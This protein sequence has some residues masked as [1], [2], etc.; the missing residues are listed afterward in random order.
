MRYTANF[1]IFFVGLL[2]CSISFYQ[3]SSGEADSVLP[4][5]VDFNYNIK[6]LLSDRC[7]ACHGPDENSREAKLSLHTEEG[8]FAAV[9]GSTTQFVIAPGDPRASAVYERIMSDDPEF[10]MPPPE[11]NLT[12]SDYEKEL[13]AK[14]IKQGATWKKHWAFIPP[15]LPTLPNVKDEEWQKNPIDAF[16]Y[17]KFGVHKLKPSEEEAPERWLRR[18]S[19]DLTGL[20][21][22]AETVDAFMTD[23]TEDDYERI[24]DD[25]LAAPSY[26]ERMASI[27]L[28]LARYADSHGYQDDKPRSIWPWRDWVIDAFNQ[29]MPYDDFVTQQVAGDLL[30]N[31]TY[32]QKL[33][34]AFNRNHAITQEGG[35][36]NEEYLTEY[37]ADRSQTFAIAFLGITMQCARCHDHKYDPL[38]QEEYYELFGFF[39]NVKDERGQISY[40]DLAPAPSIQMEDEEHDKYIARVKDHIL[41]LEEEM[42]SIKQTEQ[43]SFKTW[44]EN[45]GDIAIDLQKGLLVDY[46]L[47]EQG[48]QFMDLVSNK[49]EGR[50]NVNL[51]PSIDLP[52]LVAGRSD[53]AL[54]FNGENFL[55]LGEVGD[56]EHYQSFT[57]S[58]WIQHQG[59]LKY[60]AAIFG[61]RNDEQYR[62]GYDCSLLRNRKISMRLIHNL[63]GEM[64]EVQ[65]RDRLPGSGWH[66]LAV[67][68]DGSGKASGLKIYIDRTLQR[69][70]TI[71]DDLQGLSIT[72][73]ND[74]SV[75]NWNQRAR[76]VN[77]L[78]GF[79]NGKIDDLQIY[80]RRLSAIEIR[81]IS[82][83]SLD[84]K[85]Q[86]DQDLFEHFLLHQSDQYQRKKYTLDSLRSL[87]ISVPRIMVMEERDTIE[88]AYILDRGVYDA[89]LTPV[90]RRTPDAILPFDQEQ[91][92]RLGLAHWLFDEKNPLTARVIVNRLWQQCFGT[93]IVKS[94]ED[95]GNQGDLPTHPELLD[96]LAV[97][98]RESGWNVKNLLKSIV[99]SKTYRQSSEIT[100]KKL[101]KD[102]DNKWLARGPH[103]PLTAEMIRDQALFSSG[104]LYNKVG[105]KWVKPYQP[106]GI[107]KELANQ[108]G[109]NKYRVSI[110]KDKYRRSLY[111]YFKRTI[112][113]PTMLTLDAP[114]RAECTVKR[115]ATSTPLQALI[116]LND[117]TY[118]EASRHLAGQL[119]SVSD[120][121]AG[122]IDQAFRRILSR[123]PKESEATALFQ[124]Y[125][126]SKENYESDQAE[127]SALVAVGDSPAESFSDLAMGAAMTFT[128]SM[129]FN[130]DEAK[131]H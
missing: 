15:E 99:L 14:W 117:P 9:D 30:P 116:L 11:S 16:V 105:G 19:F 60:D 77:D 69:T 108:I 125:L 29:N 106:A 40:F 23:H 112:P 95:F 20:P 123:V 49:M 56:F 131:F 33:A 13:I 72:N 91:K 12:L 61:R 110:G 36:I 48:S 92:N 128:I 21:P 102:Y 64:I 84:L 42:S 24:V 73:G 65:T 127:A 111:T 44:K 4:D 39:N 18:V 47:D 103:N 94:V 89:R 41:S 43:H 6:P 34:T 62:Q 85:K 109:E 101:K 74:F 5:V 27:W 115:Q 10:Q 97:T 8:A 104:L 83:R 96:W 98:F 55:T 90:S 118:M 1:V 3:C 100:E 93:G 50:L 124:F 67:T 76:N 57:I 107:W 2:T 120:D 71:Q 126:D 66:H 63:Y 35:V 26:G 37:A 53:G 121:P 58:T 68:Y 86:T 130:L 59:S 75:G 7:Y 22:T 119:F 52:K 129:I 31:P 25:L 54:Q 28:D 82:G 88:K 81:S 87:D 78:K 80:D 51:P 32:G 79:D 122:I 45:T 114:E 38:S 70:T 46:P 17:E 113:P